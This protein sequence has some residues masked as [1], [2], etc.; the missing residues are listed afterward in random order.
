MTNNT[1]KV[2]NTRAT[3]VIVVIILLAIIYKVVHLI[4]TMWIVVYLLLQRSNIIIILN[5][6]VDSQHDRLLKKVK[7]NIMEC[8]ILTFQTYIYTTSLTY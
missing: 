1:R 7:H 4:L 8:M 5:S 6:K 3:V 2:I